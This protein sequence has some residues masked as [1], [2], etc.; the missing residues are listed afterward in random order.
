[1]T[2]YPQE[3]GAKEIGGASQEAAHAM[4][5]TAHMIR[6]EVFEAF[7]DVGP[8]TADEVATLLNR[9]VLSVRPRVSELFADALI[10][11]TLE[12]RPNASGMSA[13][14]WAVKGGAS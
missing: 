5:G 8:M 2:F 3:P 13:T 6:E 10:V 1:M 11:K 4:L 9:S 12:R 14:V 7:R